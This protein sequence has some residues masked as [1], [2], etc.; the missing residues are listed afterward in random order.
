MLDYFWIDR[1]CFCPHNHDWIYEHGWDP[2]PHPPQ[3]RSSGEGS[4]VPASFKS[5]RMVW[6]VWANQLPRNRKPHQKGDSTDINRPI[7]ISFPHL[8][9]KTA[10]IPWDILGHYSQNTAA[11][12]TDQ[13]NSRTTCCLMPHY[14]NMTCQGPTNRKFVSPKCKGLNNLP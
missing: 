10:S 3:K 1:G 12:E 14:V 4:V 2:H 11:M 7:F 13:N 9:L 6:A 5:L 8:A